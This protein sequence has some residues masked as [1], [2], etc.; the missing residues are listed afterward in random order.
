MKSHLY[1]VFVAVP[2][3]IPGAGAAE[4]FVVTSSGDSNHGSLREAVAAANTT[5]G[6]DIIS[7]SVSA[8]ITLSS[9]IGVHDPVVIEGH[10]ATLSGYGLVL[11]IGS[12]Q[13]AI[14]DMAITNCGGDA[15][16]KIISDRNTVRNCTFTSNANGVL[17]MGSGNTVGG[18]STWGEGNRLSGNGIGVAIAG[19]SRNCI[20]GNIIGF[21]ADQL[22]A[23][24]NAYCGI[25]LDAADQNCIGKSGAGWG[26]VIGN[27][28]VGWP[29]P[30]GGRDYP[31]GV[32]LLH[33]HQNILQNNYI[34]LNTPGD[35]APNAQGICVIG[36]DGNVIGGYRNDSFLERNIISGNADAGIKLDITT[37][38][39]IAGN[40]IGLDG[41]GARAVPNQTG[42][43]S[44][45]GGNFIGG[46]NIDSEHLR[47]NV[48]SGNS[49]CG[50]S[51]ECWEGHIVG[52]LIGVN[53][54]GNS[55]VGNGDGL[56]THV[57]HDTTIGGTD[58]S[59]RNV[60]S[61]NTQHGI[62]ASYFG[63]LTHYIQG[64]FIGLNESGTGV[65]G[66]G[67]SGM[68]LNDPLYQVGGNGGGEGNVICGESVG[69]QLSYGAASVSHGTTLTGNWIGVLGPTTDEFR[70]LCAR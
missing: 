46:A 15:G 48:I 69:I 20:L 24:P 60:I 37:G 61:G 19:G 25:F 26:N 63:G 49:L 35:P 12:S 65:I 55:A 23:W 21:S 11:A 10:G 34:G 38:N 2:L 18:N 5:T 9:D 70:F 13:S 1:A 44:H 51:V 39:V 50:I 36:S 27:N 40:Y 59:L 52:N 33:S 8:P 54:A 30:G 56:K 17:I 68:F 67:I 7:I 42:I 29:Y 58:P 22:S 66:N 31:A 41:S 28:G 16:I 62:F 47:G 6:Q 64:N 32:T 53:A 45:E 57:W 4:L 3:L 43:S 14:S